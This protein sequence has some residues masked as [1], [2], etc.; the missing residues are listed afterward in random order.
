MADMEGNEGFDASALGT[1]EEVV[2]E[3]IA[4][5]NMVMIKVRGEGQPL[6]P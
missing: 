3:R 6:T 4:D 2:E 5:D 1:S